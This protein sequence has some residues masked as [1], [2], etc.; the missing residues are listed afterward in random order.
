MSEKNLDKIYKKAKLIQEAAGPE[1]KRGLLQRIKNFLGINKDILE[2]EEQNYTETILKNYPQLRE[3]KL[4]GFDYP[5][6]YYWLG[7]NCLKNQKRCDNA[8]KSCEKK[9]KEQFKPV[10]ECKTNQLVGEVYTYCTK[11][12]CKRH[13]DFFDRVYQKYGKNFRPFYKLSNRDRDE[14]LK[15]HVKKGENPF[16]I[17]L[18]RTTPGAFD[19]FYL[20]KEGDP[21]MSK[22]YVAQ[23]YK[24][25]LSQI[26]NTLSGKGKQAPIREQQKQGQTEQVGRLKVVQEKPMVAKIEPKVQK[27]PP[28]LPPKPSYIVLNRD[29]RQQKPPILPPKP[30]IQ[31]QTN[32]LCDDSEIIKILNSTKTIEELEE[33]KKLVCVKTT[34]QENYIKAFATIIQDLN[35]EQENMRSEK[36]KLQMKIYELEQKQN[37]TIQSKKLQEQI[38]QLSKQVEDLSEQLIKKEQE[39]KDCVQ[40]DKLV[41]QENIEIQFPPPPVIDNPPPPPPLEGHI[42]EISPSRKSQAKIPIPP[43]LPV[44]PKSTVTTKNINANPVI[45]IPITKEKLEKQKIQLKKTKPQ[46]PKPESKK[47]PS[48]LSEKVKQ[49]ME[50]RRTFIGTPSEE[51]EEEEENWED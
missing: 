11:N 26:A 2:A 31:G 47:F 50:N 17:T 6:L 4:K 37:N 13:E 35:Q 32:N 51:E 3:E 34:N 43:P 5:F 12:K 44:T 39:C 10:E 28:K 16:I 49:A 14:V 41:K 48:T 33:I 24:V 45:P 40:L 29:Q 25:L 42:L 9:K 22:V 30:K 7:E 21:R 1:K 20:D 27:T 8:L 46:S 18:N 19:V 23:D 36:D 38:Q 15:Q